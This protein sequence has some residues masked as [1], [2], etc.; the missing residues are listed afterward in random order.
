[1]QS[2]T[3]TFTNNGATIEVG[4][5]KH[6]GKEFSALGS[7]ID[8]VSGVIVGYPK[9]NTLQTWDGKAIEGLTLRVTSSWRTSRSYVSSRVFAYSATY[10]GK[11]YHGRG[12]GDGMVLKLR[13]SK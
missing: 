1:M 3:E 8:E 12:A 7:V 2:Q 6:E 10:K 9:G 11:R 4:T 5:V 13:V